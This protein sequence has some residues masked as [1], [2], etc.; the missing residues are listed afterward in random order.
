MPGAPGC[1]R[2]S[3]QLYSAAGSGRFREAFEARLTSGVSS[4]SSELSAVPN[5]SSMGPHGDA[6]SVEL[7]AAA[8][9]LM[10]LPSV[11]TW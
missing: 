1:G 6:S 7:T 5:S 3:F 9:P 8:A 10:P 2:Q 11:P 4:R